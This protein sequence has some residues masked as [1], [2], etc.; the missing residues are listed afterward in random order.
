MR[1]CLLLLVN[2]AQSATSDLLIRLTQTFIQGIRVWVPWLVL[3][4]KRVNLGALC[5]L[6]FHSYHQLWAFYCP[7]CLS[8]DIFF[9]EV[10]T[11]LKLNT[12]KTYADVQDVKIK[13]PNTSLTKVALFLTSQNPS[14][15]LMLGVTNCEAIKNRSLLILNTNAG[16][17]NTKQF[18]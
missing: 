5:I 4:D 16:S 12:N 8:F 14:G 10:E 7:L 15:K 2:P 1:A 18:D 13:K 3:T 6:L 17:K 11:L 9:Y